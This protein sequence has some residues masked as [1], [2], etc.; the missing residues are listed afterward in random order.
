MF[1]DDL[2]LSKPCN[3][4][5]KLLRRRT[6]HRVD[7]I[8]MI[9]ILIRHGGKKK[10]ARSYERHHVIHCHAAIDHMFQHIAAKY[11]I[12]LGPDNILRSQGLV[13]NVNNM[14][15]PETLFL[16]A[17]R[18]AHSSLLKGLI[19]EIVDVRLESSAD[20]EVAGANINNVRV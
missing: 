12:E 17:R 10:P 6:V 15:H 3:E 19:D 4:S 20:E 8:F 1:V 11:E 14:I 2:T 13:A 7:G 18:Y 16:I 9:K 5:L